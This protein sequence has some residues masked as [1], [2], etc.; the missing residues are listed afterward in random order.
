RR[1]RI[2]RLLGSGAFGRCYRVELLNP[3]NEQIP[4]VYACKILNKTAF[5]NSSLRNR[6][7]GEITIMRSLPPHK[8]I[9]RF[10]S[11]FEDSNFVYIVM[12]LCSQKTLETLLRM[13]RTLNEYEVRYFMLQLSDAIGHMHQNK[14]IHRDIKFA[15]ILLDGNM[16]IRVTDF[17]LSARLNTDAERKRSFLGTQ[18]F[19]A[20][21]V[22]A[23][24]KFGH[25]Y[26]V[27]VW[28]LGI[29][30]YT[31]LY[32]RSPFAEKDNKDTAAL[33]QRIMNLDVPFPTL[34]NQMVS[35]DSKNLIR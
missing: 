7:L 11:C 12:E 8:H 9:V 29:M 13:R 21:E 20:P 14:V 5:K 23:K 35:D 27:D 25:S 1:Y 30:M 6:L 24:G 17:G 2:R 19:L 15:N 18:T 16:R 34:T 3:E 26:E 32:G 4:K 31:M 22:V 10:E 33:Y 28:A